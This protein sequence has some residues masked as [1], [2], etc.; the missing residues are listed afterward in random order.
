M[1]NEWQ[2]LLFLPELQELSI[3][4]EAEYNKNIPGGN[5]ITIMVFFADVEVLQSDCK[6]SLNY[7]SKS[8]V[9]DNIGD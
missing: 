5:N 9:V 6:T 8:V 1:T 4:K 2:L 7:F 3:F